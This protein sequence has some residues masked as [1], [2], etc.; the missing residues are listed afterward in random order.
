MEDKIID[1]I[2]EIS[3]FKNLRENKKI[4]LIENEILDSLGFIEL[5]SSL[6]EEFGI[7]IQI[8]E[9][10]SDTWRSVDKI[11]ELVKKLMK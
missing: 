2:E 8:T 6:E 3:E 7:E 9:V 11:A 4:D 1:I 10:K 5:I